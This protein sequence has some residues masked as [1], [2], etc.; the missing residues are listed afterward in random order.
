MKLKWTIARFEQLSLEQLHALMQLRVD[1]FV[2]EQKC[3]YRELDDLDNLA[4]TVHLLVHDEERLVGYCRVLAPDAHSNEVRIG[5]V[6]VAI[7]V[8]GKG[9]ARELMNR[10]LSVALD[11]W[12]RHAQALSAQVAVVPFYE[13]LGFLKISAEYIEDG[14]AHID[15]YRDGLTD[16]DVRTPQSA[17]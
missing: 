12:P 11:C 14:I 2:V 10:A 15:M 7:G 9:V 16:D 5:R 17:S 8:R 1:V 6:V 4:Q 3:V 13:S